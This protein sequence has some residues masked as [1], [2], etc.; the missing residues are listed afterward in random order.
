MSSAQRETSVNTI[1]KSPM[2]A[3]MNK[4]M[5]AHTGGRDEQKNSIPQKK[6]KGVSTLQNVR[7]GA[8]ST[9]LKQN[10]GQ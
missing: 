6:P 1:Y 4:S 9:G 5:L 3:T 2:R 7:G 8:S 10:T